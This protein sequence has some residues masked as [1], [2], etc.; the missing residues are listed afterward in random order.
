MSC[1]VN[2][3]MSR[4]HT[5]KSRH[6]QNEGAM[7]PIGTAAAELG[8]S[9]ETLRRWEAEGRLTSTR[10]IGGH[11]RYRLEDLD[12]LRAKHISVSGGQQK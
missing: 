8:V 5:M 11:R 9:I 10:T 1:K 6:T 2:L 12:A 4:V 3:G 7:V